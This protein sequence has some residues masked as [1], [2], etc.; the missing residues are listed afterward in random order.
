MNPILSEMI[1]LLNLTT[2]F[3]NTNFNTRP[4]HYLVSILFPFNKE[5]KFDLLDQ[6]PGFFVTVCPP[7]P[8]SEPFYCFQGKFG[9]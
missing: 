6:L 3:S 5:I 9:V 4:S 7:F 1:P 2:Y 8:T